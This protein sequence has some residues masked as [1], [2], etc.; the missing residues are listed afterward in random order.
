MPT[1]YDGDELVISLGELVDIVEL[2][3]LAAS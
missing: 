3:S 1:S 2:T